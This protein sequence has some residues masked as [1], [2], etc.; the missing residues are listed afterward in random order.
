MALSNSTNIPPEVRQYFDRLLLELARPYFNYDKFAQQRTI[1][2]KSGDIMVFRRYGTF[3]AAT[4]PITDGQTPSGNQAST[5]DFGVQL[6]QYGS[7]VTTTDRVLYTTQDNVL[8]ELTEVLALQMGLTIDT[9]IRDMMVS[10]ASTIASTGG[11]NGNTPTELTDET[12][13]NAITAL[14]LGEA[15]Y[16]TKMMDATDKFNTSPLR[17]AY[18]G[19]APEEIRKDIENIGSFVAVNNYSNQAEAL[20]AEVGTTRNVRWLTSTNGFVSTDA[21]PVYS[22]FILG[23]EAY[24]IVNLGSQNA[25]MYV[26]SLG[27]SGTADPLDQ[28]S[29]IGWK[30]WFASRILND[31]WITR[32]TST[33][34]N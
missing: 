10:T 20:D 2:E 34:G 31:N 26:K 27:S 24:G 30:I 32:V 3:A 33:L 14:R 11:S 21:T 8:N 9:L 5:L 16:I 1:P 12:V 17:K 23:Q 22:S 29:S 6:D 15:R 19:L 7:F 4:T 13:Q 25:R 18:W 28:R